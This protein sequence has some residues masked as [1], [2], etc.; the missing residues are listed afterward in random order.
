MST[1]QILNPAAA[2]PGSVETLDFARVRE[3]L[4][5]RFP[6][7]MIDKVLAWERGKRILAI[8]NV[9]GN[10]IHFLGHFPDQA[11]MPGVLIIEAMA[12]AAVILDTLSRENVEE[13][14]QITKFLTSA[15]VRFLKPVLPGDQL[16]LEAEVIKQVDYGVVAKVMARVDGVVAKGEMVLGKRSGS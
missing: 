5:H 12:Q 4:V 14:R 6:L 13:Q 8:K 2:F 7:L 15:N 16:Q 11:I 3:I 10:E 1:L 9:T